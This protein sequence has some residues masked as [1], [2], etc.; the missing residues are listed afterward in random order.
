[1]VSSFR[2]VMD[3]LIPLFIGIVLGIAISWTHVARD[4]NEFLAEQLLTYCPEALGL[5]PQDAALLQG[6]FVTE[7]STIPQTL[8]A[9]D[10]G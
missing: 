3:V 5:S 4:A 7:D 10:G 9:G 8:G 6:H 2:S 1:M